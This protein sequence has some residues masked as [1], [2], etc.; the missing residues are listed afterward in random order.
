MHLAIYRRRPGVGAVVHAHPPFATGFA[1]AGQA[2]E[3]KVL[4]EVIVNIGPIPLARYATPST[5]EV[6]SS[7]MPLIMRHDVLLLENHGVVAAG[8]NCWDAFFKMEKAEHAAKIIFIARMLGG[9]RSLTADEVE[10]L[11]AA[12]L[13]AYGKSFE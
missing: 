1:A 5:D 12:A 4:P 11:R 2:L 9:E 10:R 3:N 6:S 8:E 13:S 7:L